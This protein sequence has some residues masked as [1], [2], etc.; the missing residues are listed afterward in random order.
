MDL[1]SVEFSRDIEMMK[2]GYF[3]NYYIQLAYNIRKL[4]GTAP[5]IVQDARNPINITGDFSQWDSVTL[6]YTDPVS[7]CKDRNH[8]GYGNQ[9]YTD[10]TGR[11][12]IVASKITHD[13]KNIY[14]YAETRF[15]ISKFDGDSAWM[16]FFVDADQ[17]TATGWYGYDLIINYQA[18]DE[19]TTTVIKY[20]ATDGAYSFEVIGEVSYR[21]KDNQMMIAVP[22]E[23]LGVQHCDYVNLHFKWMDSETKVTTMEQFYTE[24]DAAPLGR[25]NYVFNTCLPG[26]TPPAEDETE[27]AED[28]STTPSD[29]PTVTSEVTEPADTRT[30]GTG[31]GSAVVAVAV[32]PAIVGAALAIRK[33]KED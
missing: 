18:T 17:N 22:L 7:D 26:S 8:Q 21:V 10:T 12:D 23:M 6:T 19:F 14:F 2:G 20:N 30:S 27:T 5:I 28:P 4:K 3:D 11:N 16:Q 32:A 31:C 15:D 9:I 24:G 33:K 29:D 25:L 13:T 1:A